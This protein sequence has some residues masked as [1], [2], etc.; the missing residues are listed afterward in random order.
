MAILYLGRLERL[1]RD[2]RRL[3]LLILLLA[4]L[5]AAEYF[6]GFLALDVRAVAD[7]VQATLHIAGLTVSFFAVGLAGQEKDEAFSYGYERAETLAAF[8]NCCFVIFECAFAS[9]HNLHEAIVGG[10]GADA[11]QEGQALAAGASQLAR[12]GL[13]RCGVNVLGLL[14]FAREARATVR[15][16]THQRSATVSAHGENM[17]SVVIKLFASA[18]GSLVGVAADAGTRLHR[19]LGGLE[20]P[21]SL[22]SGALAVYLALPP[23][24]A[25]GRVLLLAIPAEVQPALDKCLREVSFT[26]GVL[27]V[28]QWNFWPVTGAQSL[29]GTVS[30][31][32]RSSADGQAVVRTVQSLCSRVCGDLT[33]QV[34]REQPLDALLADRQRGAC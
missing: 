23:L 5:T 11:G 15:R 12:I 2:Q 25:T 16:S 34:V 26:D 30:V 3:L 6:Y 13:W 19:L 9:V 17:A 4:L 7:S 31:R 14:L 20:L 27:E 18:C 21:L 22:L 28:L 29:V 33:V 32:V 24:A 10:M 8:T 1:T